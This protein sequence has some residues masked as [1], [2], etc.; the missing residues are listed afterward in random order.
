[1]WV[2]KWDQVSSTAQSHQSLSWPLEDKQADEARTV[3]ANW[4]ETN[5]VDEVCIKWPE[6]DSP[7]ANG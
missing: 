2:G 5:S 3:K 1:M 7:E 6:S 4:P